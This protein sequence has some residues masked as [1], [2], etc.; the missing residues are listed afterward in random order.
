MPGSDSGGNVRN[1]GSCRIIDSPGRSRRSFLRATGAATVA[2]LAGCLGLFDGGPDELTVVGYEFYYPDSILEP[3]EDEHDVDVNVVGITTNTEGV[4]M[5]RTEYEG[6]ADV[7][8][9]T[10]YAV[11]RLWDQDLI[12]PIPT[13]ELE[14]Y[15]DVLE[16]ATSAPGARIDGEV[17]AVPFAFG[18]TA[19][20]YR[21]DSFD[22]EPTW[23]HLY[24]ADTLEEHDL[25]DRVSVRNHARGQ[26]YATALML[27]E[28][29]PNPPSDWDAIEE[30][31]L[32]A[33]PYYRTLW[34]TYDQHYNLIANDECDIVYGW[35]L[36][37]F[38][39]I[40]AGEPVQIAMPENGVRGYADSHQLATDA[41]NR[42][43]ALDFIDYMIAPETTL[44]T[45]NNAG[46]LPINVE[47]QDM[48]DD[49]AYEAREYVIDNLDRVK[50]QGY[51]G[52]EADER[53]SDLW[54]QIRIEAGE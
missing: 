6:E 8:G 24:D 54:E 7:V 48:M 38:A 12:E 34:E 33:F 3:F 17:S 27:G 46:N 5:M 39:L 30:T 51:W 14:H 45:M 32:D 41:P 16:V 20:V 36:T 47:G 40:D 37:G 50:V 23:E 42:D 4:G 53:A 25:D 31:L 44:E 13:A 15:D 1:G 26:I 28:D 29:D 49:D 43:L 22:E 19:P 52:D 35:D 9:L 10:N 18:A 21:T 2:G 11:Q